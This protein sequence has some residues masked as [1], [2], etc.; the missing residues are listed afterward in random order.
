MGTIDPIFFLHHTQIDRLWWLWQ[1]VSPSNR[2]NDYAG[3]LPD[4]SD[5]SLTDLMPMMGLAD[6]RMVGD[7]MSTQT[8]DLCYEY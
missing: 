8:T 4:G 6:D 5:A 3:N 1:Q 7:F 2:T